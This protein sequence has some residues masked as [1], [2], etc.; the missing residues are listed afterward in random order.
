LLWVGGLIFGKSLQEK[1]PVLQ[2]SVRAEFFLLLVAIVFL[3]LR[4]YTIALQ[5]DP[6]KQLW[7]F[8]KW[9]LG[10]LRVMNFF[11]TAWVI[12]KLLPSLQRWEIPLRPFSAVGRNMLPVF[13]F[14]IC[15][16]VLLVGVIDP[17][18]SHKPIAFILVLAQIL[19]V[20]FIAWF[21]D[22]RANLGNSV[23]AQSRSSPA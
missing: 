4:W 20:F 14:E 1:K 23:S 6:G 18:K 15:L 22:W 11:A 10:P 16:S 9:H 2:L 21:L 17:G 7:I 13:C 12:S 8:D 5:I 3:G 19:S